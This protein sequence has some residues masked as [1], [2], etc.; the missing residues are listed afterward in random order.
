MP[1]DNCLCRH[2]TELFDNALLDEIANGI[3][4]LKSH[5]YM[6]FP[7]LVNR[8]LHASMYSMDTPG[9]TCKYTIVCMCHTLSSD[10]SHSVGV[11]VEQITKRSRSNKCIYPQTHHLV[12]LGYNVSCL[13][14]HSM[15]LHVCF[16][17][18]SALLNITSYMKYTW[19]YKPNNWQ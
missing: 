6:G 12:G 8:Y 16:K 19:G 2:T 10:G 18:P 3:I 14:I 17:G 7:F 9:T 4:I 11:G 1:A 15:Q 5:S 13:H